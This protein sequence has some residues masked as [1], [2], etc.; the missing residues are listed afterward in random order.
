MDIRLDT[1]PTTAPEFTNAQAVFGEIQGKMATL[2]GQWDHLSALMDAMRILMTQKPERPDTAGMDKDDAAK[3]LAEF[4]KAMDSWKGEVN[5]LKGQ[6][7]GQQGKIDTTTKEM[8]RLQNVKLPQAQNK[9]R[10]NYEK[11]AEDQ[12]KQM[13]AV[14]ASLNTEVGQ[15]RVGG[16]NNA[17]LL[18]TEIR[19][20]DVKHQAFQRSVIQVQIASQAQPQERV[21]QTLGMGPPR[22]S[23]LTIE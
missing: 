20:M 7:D 10:K 18:R 2:R 6:I 17:D 19:Q 14:S 12:K 11:W 15:A 1:K 21:R 5:R 13:E 23:G 3:V 9:D 22:D 16:D 8:A 4:Q